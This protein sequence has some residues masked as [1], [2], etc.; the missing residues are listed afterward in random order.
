MHGVSDGSAQA[1]LDAIKAELCKVKEVGSADKIS[2]DK[3]GIAITKVVSFTSDGVSTQ[4]KFNHLLKQEMGT[5][6]EGT[7]VENKCAMHLGVNLRHAQVKAV[8]DIEVNTSELDNMGELSSD[9]DSEDLESEREVTRNSEQNFSDIDLFVHEVSKLFGHL[10]TP[11]Y[12]H[13]ASAFRVFL[14]SKVRACDGEEREYF[15]SA[16]KVVLER[17]VGSRYYVT[18][19]NACR[20]Y[21]LQKAMLLFLKE[22]QM[23]KSLNILECTFKIQ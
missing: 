7:L 15:E 13:G 8:A 16:Q 19:Y 11:E 17:Q 14:E 21:F 23:M 1:T 20:I 22:Q 5:E 18:S 9:L 3:C 4:A 10:G 6:N 2:Q 12:C